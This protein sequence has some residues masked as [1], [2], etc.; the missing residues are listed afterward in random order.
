MDGYVSELLSK[1]VSSHALDDALTVED[2]ERLLEYL[3][4]KGALDATGKYKG[5][6]LRGADTPAA[7]DGALA[8][9]RFSLDE[10]LGSR[11]GYYL[12]LGFQYQ[13]SMLQVVGG[14]DRLP[15][16]LASRLGKKITYKAAVTAIRQDG[17]GVT[18]TYRDGRGASHQVQGDYCVAAL[19]L[20]LLAQIDT[21]FAARL[22]GHH[23]ES[24]LRGG[25]QD[26]HAVQAALLGRGRPDLRRGL[27]D[28]HGD[29]ADR[30]SVL[31]LS[32]P[33]GRAGRLL[34]A[35]TGGASDW[36]QDTG[37]AAGARARA[38]RPH[39]S[40]VRQGVRERLLGGVAPRDLEQGVVVEPQPREAARHCRSRRGASISPATT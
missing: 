21:D 37:R 35:G 12:D 33:Q 36:R 2:R 31:G 19:P 9:R 8:T 13:Q 26:G 11:T 10:L 24:A 17:Q 23:R 39:P 16:A 1:A 32:Q 20:P 34:P 28:R 27:E 38:G 25:R 7:A 30:L 4:S 15:R 40:A 22:Q 29:W 5:A 14:T 18:V 6:A 3:R